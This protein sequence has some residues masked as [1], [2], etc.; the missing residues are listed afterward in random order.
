MNKKIKVETVSKKIG[1]ISVPDTHNYHVEDYK[2]PYIAHKIL[3]LEQLSLKDWSMII[4]S[5]K[6]PFC[7]SEDM[8]EGG[9]RGII[10]AFINDKYGQNIK[11]KKD[12][13]LPKNDKS[14][15]SSS[16]ED[17]DKSTSSTP[18]SEDEDKVNCIEKY[19]Q[20]T[21]HDEKYDKTNSPRLIKSLMNDCD[22]ILKGF[23][24]DMSQEFD[25]FS[26]QKHWSYIIEGKKQ[27]R[28]FSEEFTAYLPERKKLLRDELYKEYPFLKECLSKI[29]TEEDF[30]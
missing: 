23:Y 27:V 9:T 24:I 26:I 10:G 1:L 20:S 29:K 7:F 15:Y 25:F 19:D 21:F 16:S 4:A 17:D 28:S 18:S 14:T 13:F 8:R 3:N 12:Y 30:Y 22:I 2:K 6:K 11:W 5:C